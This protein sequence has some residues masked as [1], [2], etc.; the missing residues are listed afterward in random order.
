M[1][2]NPISAFN[3]LAVTP[4]VDDEFAIVDTDAGETKRITWATLIA[5]LA[6]DAELTTHAGLATGVHG[7]GGDTLATDADITTHAALATG[8]HGAG[9]DTL[10]TDADITTHAALDTGVHGAGGDTLATDADISSAVTTHAAL[11]TGIHGVGVST[12]ASAAD[13]ATHAAL[14]TGVHGAGGDTLATDADITTHAAL[15]TGIHGVG[16]STVASVANITTHAALDTGV[17][18]AGGDTLATDA[19][20]AAALVTYRSTDNKI[21]AITV[22]EPDGSEDI[23]MFFTD[24]AI[25]ISQIAVVLR[26]TS[27]SVTWALKH[28]PDRSAAGTTIEGKTTTNETT[29]DIIDQV[30]IDDPTVPANSW[31]WLETS[32]QSG[33]VDEGCW[34]LEYVED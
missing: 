8:V 31:V 10:A 2:D 24:T 22:E 26:G 19:D 25:T 32:A 15:A 5:A 29:G 3:A 17:H 18:G 1:A 11:A 14:A 7:A 20:I 16:A 4:A 34:S 21:K 12:V 27:P 9:G 23:T 6:T 13:V 33:T 30:D 28:D